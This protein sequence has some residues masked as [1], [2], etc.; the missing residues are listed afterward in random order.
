MIYKVIKVAEN[1]VEVTPSITVTDINNNPV[2]I[3]N[4][5]S[6]VSYG[7]SSI[8]G[9][10]IL[11]DKALVNAN[12]LDEEKYKQDLINEV[13]DKIERL[14]LIQTEMDK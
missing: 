3:W 12:A 11:A 6:K 10:R 9:E 1:N 7:Q 4:E 13:Q 8:D 2:E 5:D 14:N